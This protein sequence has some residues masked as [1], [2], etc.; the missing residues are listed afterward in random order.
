MMRK[1]MAGLL[2]LLLA[3]ML[4]SAALAE[5]TKENP[6]MISVM[7]TAGGMPLEY[8][9]AAAEE[10]A[11]LYYQVFAMDGESLLTADGD[12]V[13]VLGS[14]DADN[15]AWIMA[16][17]NLWF[18]LTPVPET[19]SFIAVYDSSMDADEMAAAANWLLSKGVLHGTEMRY[20]SGRWTAEVD[21]GCYL[22]QGPDCLQ[23]LNV[24][25]D[26]TVELPCAQTETETDTLAAESTAEETEEDMTDVEA[27]SPAVTEETVD[28]ATEEAETG[29]EAGAEAA[30][31]IT[32]VQ[33][34]SEAQENNSAMSEILCMIVAIAVTAMGALL[35]SRHRLNSKV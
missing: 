16:E 33:E 20:E 31:D 17:D 30:G 26:V 7:E 6:V 3:F 27:D 32:A 28:E 15:E 2:A 35:I 9:S 21:R 25:A 12:L 10:H 1:T 34:E 18:E 23:L 11:Y 29:T 13:S 5:E 14:W 8:D 22:L 24:A 19:D 4:G